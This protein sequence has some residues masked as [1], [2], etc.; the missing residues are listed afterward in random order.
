MGVVITIFF[1]AEL[2]GL[3][4]EEGHHAVKVFS[5]TLFMIRQ[6]FQCSRRPGRDL[7]C[8]A[9]LY[10][11]RRYFDAIGR[12]RRTRAWILSGHCLYL[13][14]HRNLVFARGVRRAAGMACVTAFSGCRYRICVYRPTGSWALVILLLRNLTLLI[15][16]VGSGMGRNWGRRVFLYGM[17]RSNA[18]PKSFFG[19]PPAQ[20]DPVLQ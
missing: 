11:I 13:R 19:A 6:N 7:G 20:T 14:G 9:H 12:S 10:R 5:R 15:A 3:F 1:V 2:P 16:T 18:L 8:R 4:L 17:G